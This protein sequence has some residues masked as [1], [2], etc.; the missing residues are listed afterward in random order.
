LNLGAA[1]VF[2][3]APDAASAFLFGPGG[4]S[5]YSGILLRILSL[6]FLSA[7]TTNWVQE[8]AAKA[9]VL[10]DDVHRRAN[11]SLSFFAAANL[12]ITAITFVPN[13][14]LYPEPFLQPAAAV[15]LGVLAL[16]QWWVA[17]RNYA[18][19]SPEGANPV[20]IIQSY[21]NDLS[22]LGNV[23]GLNSGIYS[24][25]TAAFVA[26]GFA[27]MVA[28]AQTLDLIFGT[29]AP[30]TPADLYLWQL[31]GGGVATVVGPLAYTQQEAALQNNFSRPDKRTLMA[32]LATASIAHTVILVPLLGTSNS[33][34]ATLP[35]LGTWVLSAIASALIAIKP[36]E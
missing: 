29:A 20:A 4:G 16:S 35:L 26:A 11:A 7:A 14:S 2:A 1:T 21:F 15:G 31:I 24:L 9:E 28:P 22:K 33:G 18:K 8:A 30:K 10:D 34:P 12:F 17:G 32:G 5:A 6:G 23:D 25:L 13:P 3:L 27:Y 19:Y 36:K